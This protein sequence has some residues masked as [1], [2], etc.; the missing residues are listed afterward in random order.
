ME[1]IRCPFDPSHHFLNPDPNHRGMLTCPGCAFS[2][3]A[4]G[5]LRAMNHSPYG[6]SGYVNEIANNQTKRG[7]SDG[8]EA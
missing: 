8:K 2:V 6:V 7:A 1:A 3:S 5:A 4:A